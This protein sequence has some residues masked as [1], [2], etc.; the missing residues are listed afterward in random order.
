M[1][2]IGRALDVYEAGYWIYDHWSYIEAYQDEPRTLDE[3]RAAAAERKKGYD[4]H[5]IVERASGITGNIPVSWLEGPENLVRIP[6]L[7]HWELN[8]WFETRNRDYGWLTPR[9]VCPRK[10][11]ERSLRSWPGGLRRWGS[12]AMKKSR[13]HGVSVE[14][15]VE[16]YAAI[17]RRAVRGELDDKSAKFDRLVDDLIA[18]E[19]ELKSRTGDERA[20][21]LKLY[22]HPNMQVR[23]N[24]AQATLAVAPEAA[25]RC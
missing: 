12:E 4:I 25:V 3:L 16:R 8:S 24:A 6:T 20:A 10:G 18:V 19:A 21:L 5:H 11:S 1:S 17:G 9:A 13:S 15:L 14:G 22:D 2:P 7:K 23:L